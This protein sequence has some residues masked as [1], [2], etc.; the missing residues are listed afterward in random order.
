MRTAAPVSIGG[1]VDHLWLRLWLIGALLALI[2]TLG[3][4]VSWW[5]QDTP[6]LRTVRALLPLATA[7][8]LGLGWRQQHRPL[9]WQLRW[10][11]TQWWWCASRASPTITSPI[12]RVVAVQVRLDLHDMLL[13]RLPATDARWHAPEVSWLFLRRSLHAPQWHALR[14]AVYSPRPSAAKAG[15]TSPDDTG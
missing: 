2:S 13:L 1:E 11:G 14:C 7:L 9:R 15:F 4:C 6:A 3:W 12:E 10:D 8:L 5:P